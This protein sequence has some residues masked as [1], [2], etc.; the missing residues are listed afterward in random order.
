MNVRNAGAHALA[1]NR[2]AIRQILLNTDIEYPVGRLQAIVATNSAL[3]SQEEAEL[4]S[5]KLRSLY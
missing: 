5:F 2:I 1:G 3:Y 4:T